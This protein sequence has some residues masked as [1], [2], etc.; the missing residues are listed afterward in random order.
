METNSE[1][2]RVIFNFTDKCNLPCQFCYIPFDRLKSELNLWKSIITKC[3]EWHPQ[4][5][6]FGGGDPFLYQDFREL[7]HYSKDDATFINVDTNA[8][9]LRSQDV[10]I[11]KECV[12]QVGLPIEG[13]E[14]THTIMRYNPKHFRVVVKW[15]EI[16]LD[17]GIRIKINTVVSKINHHDLKNLALLLAQYPISQWCLYQFWPLAIGKENQKLYALT[18]KE[19]L[20]AVKPIKENFTFTHI[21]I[22]SI[23]KRLHSHFFVSHT[24]KVYSD[25]KDDP[26]KYV[27]I[28]SIFEEDILRKWRNHGDEYAVSARARLRIQAYED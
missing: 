7:L 16:L 5:I 6:V 12:N 10:S 23:S 17:A 4:I 11:L 21:D 27:P 28:G 20:A 19:F 18:D 26:E 9:A 2:S 1:L 24:G 8:L 22:A 3:K 13:L 15:L 14:E 25:H